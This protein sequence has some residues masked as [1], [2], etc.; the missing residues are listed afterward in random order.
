MQRICKDFF[1]EALSASS[2]M[3]DQNLISSGSAGI[4]FGNLNT[5]DAYASQILD[6]NAVVEPLTYPV[7]D[8]EKN[9]FA[10]VGMPQLW[11]VVSTDCEN[12]ELAIRFLNY[13]F[14][15]EGQLLANYGVEGL[16]FEMVDGKPA[17][18]DIIRNNPEGMNLDVALTLYTCGTGSICTVVDNDKNLTL[19]SDLQNAAVESW[20]SQVDNENIILSV[21][22]TPDEASEYYT[23]MSDIQTYYEQAVPEFIMGNRPLAEFDAYVDTMNSMGLD[24][25]IELYQTAYDRFMGKGE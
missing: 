13:Y 20:R 14:T 11:G 2:Y 7:S 22:M 15:E 19:Y 16:T 10:S 23:L 5:A 21:S 25:C 17:F 6:E 1:S 4:F 18:T 24:H 12:P 3:T 8:G 9:H